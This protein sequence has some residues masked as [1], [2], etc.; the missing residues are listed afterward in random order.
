LKNRGWPRVESRALPPSPRGLSLLFPKGQLK[1]KTAIAALPKTRCGARVAPQRCPILRIGKAA[2]LY[3]DRGFFIGV[4]LKL[5]LTRG[6]YYR[7]ECTVSIGTGVQIDRNM[8]DGRCEIS[9]NRAERSI[10]PFVIDR[11]NFL[12]A[13][14]PRGASVSVKPTGTFAGVSSHETIAPNQA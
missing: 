12:F 13:N 10:K 3:H 7:R 6:T 9:N 4:H 2:R 1:R 8:H 11:K 5:S 14:T